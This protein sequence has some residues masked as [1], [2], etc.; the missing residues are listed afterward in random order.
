MPLPA[1]LPH[2]IAGI[3]LFSLPAG[4]ILLALFHKVMKIPLLELVPLS[5]RQRLTP[6]ADEFVFTPVRPL[7]R[8]TV[9]LLIGIGTHLLWDAFTSNNGWGVLHVLGFREH[10][11]SPAIWLMPHRIFDLFTTILGAGLLVAWY[12]RWYLR[13]PVADGI[14]ESRPQRRTRLWLLDLML[15]VAGGVG[16]IQTRHIV[17]SISCVDDAFLAVGHF[18]ISAVPIL[19]V[20][21]LIYSVYQQVV[22]PRLPS[23][24]IR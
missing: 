9:S 8:I 10:P 19:F 15:V 18:V 17:T 13:A 20:E 14:R 16:W 11:R 1:A 5:H 7:A 12:A 6:L 3:F 2:S 4:F 21:A 24:N 22:K 23:K